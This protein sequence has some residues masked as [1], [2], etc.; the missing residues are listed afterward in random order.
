MNDVYKID[1]LHKVHNHI[2][3]AS[4]LIAE[5]DER[6][7]VADNIKAVLRVMDYEA[8]LESRAM[9]DRNGIEYEY[10]AMK[11]EVDFPIATYFEL[12]NQIIGTYVNQ[13]QNILVH[14]ACGISRSPTIVTAWIVQ[15]EGLVWS[16]ILKSMR[17]TQRV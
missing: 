5:A 4:E 9:Y 3:I 15:E 6:G 11:D 14:C 12:T 13:N 17:T 2:Y 10:V 8:P 7:L 16:D 1:V